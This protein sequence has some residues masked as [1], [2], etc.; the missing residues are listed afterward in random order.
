MAL[1]LLPSALTSIGSYL[2]GQGLDLLG[3]LFRGAIDEGKEKV[4]TAIEEATGIDINDAAEGKLTEE[5]LVALRQFEMQHQQ[6]LLEQ[7]NRAREIEIREEEIHQRDRADAR[8]LQRD[9]I[10][11]ED[12]VVRRFI[13]YYAFFITAVTFAYIFSVTWFPV[14]EEQRRIVDTVLG[15]LLGVSLSAVIQFF[16][17]SSQGSTD[18]QQQ[19]NKLL[20]ELSSAQT[21]G[22]GR[23][24]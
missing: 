19:I 6:M 21:A 12:P 24:D 13:Y 22:S 20:S 16:F 18:K 10:R 2:A 4:A 7:L 11:S 15:F 14:G 17:G 5:Q 3:S 23:R 9:A 8:L 1:P